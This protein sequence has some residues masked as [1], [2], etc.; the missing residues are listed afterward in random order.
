M[1]TLKDRLK[2]LTNKYGLTTV[3][4]TA[5]AIAVKRQQE[6]AK[7]VSKEVKREKEETK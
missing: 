2:D 7:T 5:A 3:P 6:A 4:E 1:P